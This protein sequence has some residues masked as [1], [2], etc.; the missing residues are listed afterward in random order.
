MPRPWIVQTMRGGNWVEFARLPFRDAKATVRYR[1]AE[2][3]GT[4]WRI[5]WRDIVVDP[6]SEPARASIP[7][8]RINFDQ[9]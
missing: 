1:R 9:P 8:L 3:L 7:K 5:V 4:R 2:Y 6:A